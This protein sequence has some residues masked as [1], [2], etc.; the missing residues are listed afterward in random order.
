[1]S[2]IVINVSMQIG[3]LRKH[4]EEKGILNL[5]VIANHILELRDL[6]CKEE[7]YSH[8]RYTEKG[9]DVVC[10]IITGCNTKEKKCIVWCV[11]HYL[12]L[13]RNKKVIDAAKKALDEYG[14]GCGTS[15]LSGGMTS[16]HKMLEMRLADLIGKE[17]VTLFPTGY[18]ANLGLLSGIAGKGSFI[19]FD[20]ESHASIVDGA[21]LSGNKY[22]PFNHNDV[23]DLDSK[24]NKYTKEYENI[25]VVVESAYS[26]S[27]D[28]S[29]LKEIVE[30][31]QK[32]KFYLIVDE[33]HTFGF[34]GKKG[35]GYR[36]ELGVTEEVD[37][38]VG[39][40]SKATASIGGYVASQEKY[41]ILLH[42]SATP[43]IF[44]ACTP[45]SDIAA[46]LACLDEI[47][48]NTELAIKLHNNNKHFRSLLTKAGF[49]LRNSQSPI[50]PVY[51]ED[52][53]ALLNIS[54]DL[55]INGIFTNA[56]FYP[57][58]KRTE[59]R[60]RFILNV[61]HTMEQMERTVACLL[62]A[63]KKY[64]VDITNEDYTFL[65][66]EKSGVN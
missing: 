7:M 54:K 10:N 24:L 43:F 13:N 4:L 59:G 35:S 32:Y 40:L 25:F 36:N 48:T 55:Y 22:L 20:R 63:V 45:P 58:V 41:D 12:G 50:V 38:I 65:H 44:Q 9:S 62:E 56:I 23:E 46:S 21:K 27:G 18:T 53:E 37:F 60:L 42:W 34:Y 66:K 51:I 15:A 30:L 47:E 14:T 28:L 3:Y 31:K 29:P 16:L 64:G 61:G 26:M 6:Q 57:A 19:L 8:S 2:G 1:M 39:T 5:D 33:A 49:D 52:F 11:N 17:C